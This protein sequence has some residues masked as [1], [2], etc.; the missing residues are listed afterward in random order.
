MTRYEICEACEIS[1]QQLTEFIEEGL[2]D[3][4][5][6]GP[7]EWQFHVTSLRRIRFAKSIRRDLGVNTAGAALALDLLDRIDA[8]KQKLRQLEP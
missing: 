8:L 6:R 1:V 3:A 5:G 2:V 7:D 4:G